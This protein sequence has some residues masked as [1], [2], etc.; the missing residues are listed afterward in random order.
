MRKNKMYAKSSDLY[1]QPIEMNI[2]NSIQGSSYDPDVFGPSFW[3]TL[4]NGITTYPINPTPFVQTG[5]KQLLLN[6]P[7]IVPCLSCK[8]HFYSFLRNSNLDHATNSR[9]NLFAFFVDIHNYVN[10]RYNKPMMT[11]E[12]AKR[13][14][15]YDKPTGVGSNVRITYS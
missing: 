10:K 6:L 3:F 11:L 7:L 14:Y 12:D 2:T 15:G 5:M 9:E 1:Q 13:M 8:E 4:H